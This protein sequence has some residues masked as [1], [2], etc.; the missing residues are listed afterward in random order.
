[1]KKG[2][3]EIMLIYT[4]RK[5]IMADTKEWEKN[6][7]RNVLIVDKSPDY[8][9]YIEQLTLEVSKHLNIYMAHTLEE[10]YK[11]LME[12]TMDIFIV[13]VMLD[14]TNVC[15][16]SGLKL[17]ER[18]REIPKYTFTPVIF[19]SYHE[20]MNL[21]A[22]KELHCLAYM[23]NP[24]IPKDFFKVMQKAVRFK[25]DR[26]EDRVLFFRKQGIIY[27]IHTKNI[28]YVNSEEHIM[29]FHMADGT[30]EEFPY[31]T[32]NKIFKEAAVEYLMQCRRDI[33]VN[34]NYILGIDFINGVIIL[35]NKMG[36]LM[37]GTTF[38]KRVKE[39]F[40]HSYAVTE[41]ENGIIYID[42]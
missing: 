13:D 25:T 20:D 30:I 23:Y 21:H 15:D 18:I 26:G 11:R 40:V 28:V 5:N 8:A 22:F 33:V 14:S 7:K 41:S 17:V 32:F 3:S 36:Y 16:T 35:K 12:I 31:R 9:K 38:R 34:K 2:K 24:V 39:E 6:M 37:I 42:V 10:A 1:M 27:A 19:T 29:Y 4:I